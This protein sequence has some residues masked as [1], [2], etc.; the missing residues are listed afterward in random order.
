MSD[1]S[2]LLDLSDLSDKL[3]RHGIPR[4][5]ALP[6][7]GVAREQSYRWGKTSKQIR[8]RGS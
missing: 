5:S 2:D 7:C 8:R 4:G 6:L 1:L 3:V